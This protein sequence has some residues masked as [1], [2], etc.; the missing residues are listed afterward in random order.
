MG[1]LNALQT[2]IDIY[3]KIANAFNSTIPFLLSN[4]ATQG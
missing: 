4:F 2:A 3:N 1:W